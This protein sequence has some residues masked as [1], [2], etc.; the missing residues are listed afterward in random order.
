LSC[1]LKPHLKTI[2]H[3]DQTGYIPGSSIQDNIL[4]LLL[5]SQHTDFAKFIQLYLDFSKA[6]D[7]MDQD[8]IDYALKKY[9]F[10]E[11]YR[12]MVRRIFI[13][14]KSFVIVNGVRTKGFLI[15]SGVRQGD[16]IAG[17]LFIIALELL[18]AAIRNSKHIK[19][20]TI[21]SVEKKISLHCDDTATLDFGSINMVL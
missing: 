21:G 8:F 13:N 14:A 5:M 9:G 6:F 16:P 4:A 15:S 18:A 2:I 19:G 1:R 12:A 10:G 3:E 7:S 11:R 17:F 20:C